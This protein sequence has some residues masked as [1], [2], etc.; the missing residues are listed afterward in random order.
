MLLDKIAKSSKIKGFN[1]YFFLSVPVSVNLKI[2]D[3]ITIGYPLP[4][5]NYAVLDEHFNIVPI[6]VEG[7]LV[8]SGPGVGQ[9][10]TKKIL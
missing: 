1:V 2:G 5:Y 7:E 4:N 9:G 6:G 3:D 8:I 10:H